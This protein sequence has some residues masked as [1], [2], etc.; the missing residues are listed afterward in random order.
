M[1]PPLKAVANQMWLCK[2]VPFQQCIILWV[3]EG[4]VKEVRGHSKVT[5]TLSLD[6]KRAAAAAERLPRCSQPRGDVCFAAEVVSPFDDS[7]LSQTRT[8]LTKEC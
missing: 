1:L 8:P 4:E 6:G 2:V 7:T 3:G 5:E